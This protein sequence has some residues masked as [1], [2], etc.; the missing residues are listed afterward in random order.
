MKKLIQKR[1]GRLRLFGLLVLCALSLVTVFMA[2]LAAGVMA[3]TLALPVGIDLTDKEKAAM[4]SVVDA[5]N[6]E[7]DRLSK[8]YITEAKFSELATAAI[9][10]YLKDNE[11]GKAKILELEN[12]LKTQGLEIVSL[13]EGKRET[14]KSFG[15]N[16]AEAYKANVEAIKAIKTKQGGMIAFEIKDVGTMQRDTHVTGVSG[17]ME[18]LETGLTRIARRLPFLRDIMNTA[19]TTSPIIKYVEYVS[20]QGDA[21][22]TGEGKKK[23]QIDFKIVVKSA[24]A[25]KVT[26]FIKV[27]EEMIEDI[28]FI[29]GEI[30]GDLVER[31]DLKIDADLLS[32]DGEDD[33]L[34]GLL[35]YAPEFAAGSFANTVERANKFDVLRTAV[36]LIYSAHFIPN[37][38]L[39]NPLD[40]AS[41]ELTKAE[42]GHYILP[43][44]I[45]ADGKRI[46]GVPIIENAGITV[47]DFVVGDFTKSNLRIRKDG[48]LKVGYEN[49]D[50]TNN[51]ITILV[52]ARMVHYIKTNHLNAFLQG[53]FAT[54]I[55]AIAAEENPS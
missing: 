23:S 20:P 32:G 38:I 12:A 35:E 37:Y 40:A 34:K 50:F 41:M 29:Q 13:K 15:Q 22:A 25:K 21:A 39:V 10:D 52:E 5:V 36:A 45:T 7:V 47:G 9:K 4:Q 51:L 2:P 11:P 43:P 33:N 17:L 3:A 14:L 16:V 54:A 44:F 19:N 55:A 28:P 27:S 49:D 53:D 46:G 42:D 6:K 1:N 30:N 18:T 24:E 48:V 26:A 8:G 31:L